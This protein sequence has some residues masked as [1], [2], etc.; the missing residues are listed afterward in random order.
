MI[1]MKIIGILIVLVVLLSFGAAQM[2]TESMAP[3]KQMQTVPSSTYQPNP[4]SAGGNALWI[5]GGTDL[6]QYAQVPFG[7]VV[8]LVAI[9]P[10]GGNGYLTD[11]M[12]NNEMKYSQNF[13]FTPVKQT[14][15]QCLSSRAPSNKIYHWQ[16]G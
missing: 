13:I 1:R 6:N 4:T 2:S 10:S 12:P 7:T 15:I 3:Q 9:S 11:Q 16:S 5:G 8:P 14:N